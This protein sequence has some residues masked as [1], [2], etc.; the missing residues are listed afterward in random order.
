MGEVSRCAVLNKTDNMPISTL[1]GTVVVERIIDVIFLLGL[2]LL[3]ILILYKEINV[4]V[5]ENFIAPI[6]T[7][8][9]SA[10]GLII[11][12]IGIALVFGILFFLVRK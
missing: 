5:F 3:A 12:A 11:P 4:F 7:K 6:I 2:G 9:N 1:I 10:V 8:L